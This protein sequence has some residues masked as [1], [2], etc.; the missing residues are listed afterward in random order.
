[1]KQYLLFLLIAVLGCLT[2]RSGDSVRVVHSFGADLRGAYVFPSTSN[3]VFADEIVPL[4]Y[5]GDNSSEKISSLAS[6]H[7]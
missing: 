5:T 4:D 3:L 1:M 2:A 7:A 6:L